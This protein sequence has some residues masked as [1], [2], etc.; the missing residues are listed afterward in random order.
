MHLR[1]KEV[2]IVNYDG[3]RRIPTTLLWWQIRQCPLRD[4]NAVVELAV[5][6]SNIPCR[7]R[8]HGRLREHIYHYYGKP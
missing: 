7:R 6:Q 4:V 1:G 5:L 3:L 8:C 2:W